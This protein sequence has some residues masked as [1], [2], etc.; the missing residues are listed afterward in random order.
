MSPMPPQPEE[1]AAQ[2]AKTNARS[3]AAA[4]EKSKQIAQMQ[5]RVRHASAAVATSQV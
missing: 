5:V 1:I 2:A 3:D 4:S